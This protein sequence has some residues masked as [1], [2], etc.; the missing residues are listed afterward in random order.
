MRILAT[1]ILLLAGCAQHH[2]DGQADPDS[3]L[4]PWQHSHASPNGTR[5]VH[6]IGM[7]PAFLDR[8]VIIEAG[9]RKN[10]TET[11]HELGVELEWAIT[12]RIGLAVAAPFVRVSPN[13]DQTR[14]GIGDIAFAPPAS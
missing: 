4:G 10:P 12:N 9:K 8:E 6:A 11:E 13:G 1:A 2:S 5:F 3:W 7:E 14:E